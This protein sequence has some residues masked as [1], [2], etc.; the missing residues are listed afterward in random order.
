MNPQYAPAWKTQ[1]Y[2]EII[3]LCVAGCQLVV[4]WHQINQK[5]DNQFGV[6]KYNP[7][8]SE[9]VLGWRFEFQIDTQYHNR[10]YPGKYS[11]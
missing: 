2:D 7:D 4:T 5:E 6:L 10:C 3:E 8:I 9:K 1:R 11:I